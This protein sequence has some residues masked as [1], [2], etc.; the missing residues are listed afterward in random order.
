MAAKFA[1]TG[2]QYRRIDRRLREIQRQLDQEGG[3]PLDPKLVAGALQQIVEGRFEVQD[4]GSTI[5]NIEDYFLPFSDSDA[6]TALMARGRSQKLAERMV[7][8]WRFLATSLNYT[9]PVCWQVKAG[10]TMKEHAPKAGP[11]YEGFQ[12]LQN[13]YFPD[14]PTK[15]G[16]VFWIPRFLEESTGKNVDE[17]MTLL[18][19]TRIRFGLP[20]HHLTSYG[21]ASLLAGLILAHFK[22]TGERIPQDQLWIRTDTRYADGYRL[23][24]GRFVG[25]GL[26][27]GHWECGGGGD[28]DLGCFPLGVD[29]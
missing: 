4:A 3:S 17:Q 24:L 19:D 27:C 2:D 7:R 14:E 28:D 22:A 21:Q 9:G 26:G 5:V 8:V 11:C 13:W 15:D 29:P 10:F 6:I 23:N 20:D 1:V 16:I 12:Y 25:R 18:T